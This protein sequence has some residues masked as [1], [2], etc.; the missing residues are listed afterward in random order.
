MYE[1]LGLRYSTL[2]E[3]AHKFLGGVAGGNPQCWILSLMHWLECFIRDSP[4]YS[5]KIDIMYWK[6]L[7]NPWHAEDIAFTASYE[8]PWL[9]AFLYS[10]FTLPFRPTK[11]LILPESKLPLWNSEKQGKYKI[12]NN[13]HC[14]DLSTVWLW[15]WG[16][17][18]LV[19]FPA[20]LLS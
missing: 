1:T 15:E 16:N 10:S 20:F 8:S 11:I 17:L 12:L 18:H 6:F 4:A 14:E 19:M 2:V 9:A 7:K 5:I 13:G 3:D